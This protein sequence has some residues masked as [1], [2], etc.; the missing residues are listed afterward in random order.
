MLRIA[1]ARDRAS[2]D[3]TSIRQM[4]DTSGVVSQEDDKIWSRWEEYFHK[5]QNEEN[6]RGRHEDREAR[7]GVVQ[8]ISKA[9][10]EDEKWKS[11]GSGPNTSRSVEKSREGRS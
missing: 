9:E 7:E 11:G 2:K 8:D 4:K 3:I 5:L 6:P 10:M 1:K